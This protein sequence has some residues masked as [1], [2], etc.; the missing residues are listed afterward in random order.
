MK[1]KKYLVYSSVNVIGLWFMIVA[2]F[3]TLNNF[4]SLQDLDLN[5]KINQHEIRWAVGWLIITA[6]NTLF[7]N[8][9]WQK[10]KRETSVRKPKNQRGKFKTYSPKIQFV[11]K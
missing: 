6:L 8:W 10:E 11:N 9:Y 5:A 4:L 7:Q 2:Q 1:Y 3:S